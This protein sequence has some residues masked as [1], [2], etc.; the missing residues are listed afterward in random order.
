M[1][2]LLASAVVLI[3]LASG[4]AFSQTTSTLTWYVIVYKTTSIPADAAQKVA[5]AGGTLKRTYPQ[6]GVALATTSLTGFATNLLASGDVDSVQADLGY[7]A[8][9]NI[10]A[11]IAAQ[12][13]G[14]GVLPTPG[15]G[16]DRLA[17]LQWDMDM[18]HASGEPGSGSYA[19]QH[20]RREVIAAILDTG[21]DLTHPE[22]MNPDLTSR[23]DPRSQ[24]FIKLDNNPEGP[25]PQVQDL[26]GHGTHVAG[27]VAAGLNGFGISGVA[28]NVTLVA[29]KVCHVSGFCF[30]GPVVE[31]LLYA[32]QQRFDVANMSFFVDPFLYNCR[33]EPTQRAI[34]KAVSRAMQFAVKQGVTPV[35]A[36]GNEAHDLTH[37]E[38]DTISP[39]F[40]PEIAAE[41]RPVK[42]HCVLVPQELL[43]VI[44]VSALGP[45]RELAVYSNFGSGVV[46][47]AAPGGDSAKP[48]PFL[49]FLASNRILSTLP[50]L[51]VLTAQDI[52]LGRVLVDC[53]TG[54][55]D[56]ASVTL[57]L[58]PGCGVY[59]WLQGTSMASPHAAG[60]A[61]LIVSQFGNPKMSPTQV[62]SQLQ[63]TALDIGKA[64]ADE[65][66]GHGMVHAFN[67]V[68]K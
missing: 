65:L 68:T 9:P 14:L 28:P 12:N 23:I 1:N 4:T 39:D 62:A 40:P 32:G 31:A 2:R 36:L 42:N 66:Y 60:V 27:S 63:N 41:T 25:E 18:I 19:V 17:G 20:G 15:P 16:E 46:D 29:L 34:W 47:V 58:P 67:A 64:G 48:A 38:E 43:G 7:K 59:G 26:N 49:P 13:G 35:A 52:A 61:A 51:A 24:S 6:I 56:P 10:A 3:F 21:I 22:F 37:P 5:A 8:V 55:P 53:N 50:T 33:D 54:R 45:T 30:T 57:P 11:A 44:G